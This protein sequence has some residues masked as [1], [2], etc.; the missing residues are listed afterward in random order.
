MHEDVV[1]GELCRIYGCH[2]QRVVGIELPIWI[3]HEIRH[4][5]LMMIHAVDHNT[6]IFWLYDMLANNQVQ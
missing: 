3:P 5:A 6:E 4:N 2:V 1:M